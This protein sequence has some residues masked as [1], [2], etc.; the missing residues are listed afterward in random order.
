VSDQQSATL[1]VSIVDV[2]V[3]RFTDAGLETLLLRRAPDTRC[4]GAWEIVHGR[5]EAGERPEAAALREVREETQLFVQRL[6]NVTLGGFYL[7]QTG[8][9]SLSVVFCAI[10]ANDNADVGLGSEHDACRWLPMRDAMDECAWPREREA[11]AH[12][13]HLLRN[14][15]DAGAVD[16]VLRVR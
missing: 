9:V 8:V 12:I 1:R 10:V 13:T 7:H 14:G 2:V 15:R 3:V 4:T 5:I 16:D 11:M 6:Y